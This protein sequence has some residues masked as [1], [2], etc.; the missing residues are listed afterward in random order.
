LN[1][2]LLVWFRCV[3]AKSSEERPCAA[4]PGT[5]FF[6]LPG[7]IMPDRQVVTRPLTEVLHGVIYQ[8][9]PRDFEGLDVILEARIRRRV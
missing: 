2:G 6:A 4:P 8:H 9:P 5:R 1:S 3:M 7:R